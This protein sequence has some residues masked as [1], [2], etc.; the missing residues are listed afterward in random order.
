[1]SFVF[2]YQRKYDL[3]RMSF[4]GDRAN[5]FTSGLND[6]KHAKKGLVEHESSETLRKFLL[7]CWKVQRKEVDFEPKKHFEKECEYWSEVLRTV[8][9]VIQFLTLLSYS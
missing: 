8:V 6:W 1:M 3:L 2:A 9:A 5:M 7:I 4:F